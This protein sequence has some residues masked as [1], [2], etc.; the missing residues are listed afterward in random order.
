MEH[1]PIETYRYPAEDY[2]APRNP[3][4][5]VWVSTMRENASWLTG[6]VDNT[7]DLDFDW[8]MDNLPSAISGNVNFPYEEYE[9]LLQQLDK[10]IQELSTLDRSVYLLRRG[11]PERAT[12]PEQL[13]WLRQKIMFDGEATEPSIATVSYRLG[14]LRYDVMCH[15][16]RIYRISNLENGE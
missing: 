16:H 8:D 2:A 14:K 4:E 15:H 1:P 10:S 6:I 13:E 7:D 9:D 3:S 12:S 5:G 11:M